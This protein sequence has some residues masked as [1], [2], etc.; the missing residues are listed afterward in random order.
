MTHVLTKYEKH[1]S[2]NRLFKLF[3]GCD[4]IMQKNYYK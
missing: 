4:E 1:D 3:T 2:V